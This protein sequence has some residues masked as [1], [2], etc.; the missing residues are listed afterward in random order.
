MVG[1]LGIAVLLG[2][3]FALSSAKRSISFRTVGG[4]FAM[5]ALIGA[6]VLYSELG[7]EVL[8]AATGF[9]ANIIAY[10]Q[11]GID[12]LFGPI[13]DK[14][15]AFIFAFNVLP[16]I[17]FFSS[18][19]AVLYHLKVMGLIIKVIGGFL[20]KVLRTSRPESMSAAANIFVG[21]TEAPLVVR[22]F[23][24]HMTRS[25]LFAV[26]VGGLASIAG[27]VMAGYAGMGVDLK[28]LLAASFMAAPGGMLMAKIILPETEEP[29]DGLSE[30][31]SEDTGY[32]NVFDAAASGAASGMTLALNV[33]A[34][35]LAFIA[36]I[37]MFNGLVGWTGGLLGY[38]NVTF[39]GIMGYILQPLAWAIGVPWEEA[40][41]AGSFIGQKMVVNEFVAYLNY[42]EHQPNLSESTQAI[43]TFALCGF[44]N[45]SSIA[46]LMGGIGA[47]APTRRKEIA[48]LGLKAVI[49]ATLSN[50]M[51]AALAGFYLALG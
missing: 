36:L 33:G 40:Q 28:Y 2:I 43:V 38:E 27:S 18:L 50:L 47:M 19:I 26:M 15:I 32:A 21:Q 5:Q 11:D 20:Q 23:I 16:V 12:F 35:L 34:M 51:S 46:I 7:K 37:A 22:P 30:I 39:E 49:A 44:A 24:P 42:L 45:L 29:K 14:S 4:A 25:E 41:I 9:V 1:L 8:L 10:S 6:F 13:G 31:D 3:A 17:V 48:Q